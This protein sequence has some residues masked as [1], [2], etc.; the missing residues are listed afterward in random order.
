M[1]AKILRPLRAAMPA[2]VAIVLLGP[3]VPRSAVADD[4]TWVE[5]SAAGIPNSELALAAVDV[6]GRQMYLY[7]PRHQPTQ[8]AETN[9]VYAVDFTATPPRIR[10]LSAVG[11]APTP[12]TDAALLFDPLRHRLLLIGGFSPVAPVEGTEVWQLS[13]DEPPHWNRLEAL[14]PVPPPRSKHV[15]IYD[16]G[17]DRVVLHGGELAEGSVRAALNDTWSL[18]LGSTP[19]WT[20][21]QTAGAEAPTLTS[22]TAIHDSR[23]DR[24]VVH[25]GFEAGMI[26]RP[27]SDTWTLSLAGIPTWSLAAVTSEPPPGLNGMTAE[28]VYDSTYDRMLVV[29]SEIGVPTTQP[30]I[31]HQ[32]DFAAG[33]RWD[34]IVG[35][36]SNPG[37]RYEPSVGLLPWDHRLVLF[38]GRIGETGIIYT[39][40]LFAYDLG[41]G[42]WSDLEP[43]GVRP[44]RELASPVGVFDHA[45]SRAI[46]LTPMSP[47]ETWILR[48]DSTAVWQRPVP[49]T[50]VPGVGGRPAVYDSVGERVLVFDGVS[51]PN[52]RVWSMV[53]DPRPAWSFVTTSSA[54]SARTGFAVTY[55]PNR[56]RVLLFGG[57]VGTSASAE[58]WELRLGPNPE[59]LLL[60]ATGPSGRRDASM[61]LDPVEQRLVLYGGQT[62]EVF[63]RPLGGLWAWPLATDAGWTEL[64]HT[65]SPP[66]P[67]G[68]TFA[69][70]PGRRRAVL[71]GPIG[72]NDEF[73]WT[74]SFAPTATWTPLVVGD[75]ADASPFGP[76][77]FDAP[78]DRLLF[79]FTS[80][81][82]G[83]AL[84]FGSPPVPVLE[85]PSDGPWAPGSIRA[86]SFA[87]IDE[88]GVDRAYEYTLE[89]AREWPGFPIRGLVFAGGLGTEYVSIGIPVPDTAAFGVVGFDL[90]LRARGSAA[91]EVSC[92]FQLNGEAAPIVADGASAEPGRVVVQWSSTRPGLVV[93]VARRPEDGAWRAI[94]R[95]EVPSSG[96]LRFEDPDVEADRRYYYRIDVSEPE[97]A[98]SYGQIRVDVPTGSSGMTLAFAPDQPHPV[99]GSLDVQFD[100][101]A[102]GDV[103][104]EGFDVRGRRAFAESR[105]YGSAG[106]QSFRV[107]DTNRLSAGVYFVRLTNDDRT[108]ERRLVFLR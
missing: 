84:Q 57:A 52:L 3:S 39:S 96:L 17:R 26:A 67:P 102:A 80:Y 45:R 91:S 69:I 75:Q 94:E 40:D 42:S 106:R 41:A 104:L 59:W 98:G 101:P 49:S 20:R 64:A 60:S 34:P 15:A 76:G 92:S 68:S 70:D 108:I 13:L 21:L 35:T 23:R 103:R 55:D 47:P 89:S 28:A 25:G 62:V 85:C 14:G 97:I 19:R 11:P 107:S 82:N 90:D 100:L 105:S 50:T 51:T 77:F 30:L 53:P 73:A 16:P 32:L 66:Q 74:L 22:A 58:L 29:R 56:N 36:G 46:L 24:M 33:N 12:R 38:G 10:R 6:A 87:L 79:P 72:S 4:G 7:G 43:V 63:P 1:S 71:A 61:A 86:V 81:V 18:D 2:V 5:F 8:G 95:I 65:G 93:T 54:P 78:R 27:T 37:S 44:K 31:L 99:V 9:Q 88:S 48:L 83:V